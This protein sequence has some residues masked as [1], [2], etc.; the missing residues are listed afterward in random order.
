MFL[1]G[2][3][4][5]RGRDGGRGRGG[6]IPHLLLAADVEDSKADQAEDDEAGAP[7]LQQAAARK[8]ADECIVL[9]HLLWFLKFCL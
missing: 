7:S 1:E 5:R 9:G 8:Q 3:E 2:G 6:G 4:G